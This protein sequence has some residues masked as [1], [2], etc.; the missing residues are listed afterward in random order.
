MRPLFSVLRSTPAAWSVPVRAVRTS[1]QTKFDSICS[2]CWLQQ[3]RQ[4]T[5]SRRLTDQNAFS[6]DNPAK[7]VRVNQKHG[8]GLIII[9]LIP[10]IAFGLGTWQVQRLDRK[11]QM[12]AKF[13]DRLTRPP[14]PL[15]PRIDP[16]AISEFD[17]RRVY[18]T[19]TLRHDKEMLVGP[20]INEGE[21][22][23][24]VVTPLERE[25]QSTVLVNRGWISRKLENQKDRPDGIK[26]EVVTVEG[27]L[28]EPWKK[29]MFTPDNKPEEGKFY[30]PD[31]QQMA[32]LS[33]SQ[34]V[35]IEETMVPDLVESYNREAK[36]IPIGRAAEVNLRN[37]HAQYIF[38][39]YGLSLATSIML[40]M[41]VRKKPS[42]EAMRRVRQN[43]NW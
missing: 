43:R 1:E 18:A 36:G 38:T 34:P 17:Y 28:R 8:P 15:P 24:L 25:G 29:N 23:Y 33:G 31:I 30:F 4:F 13:E 22:G 42:S 27:L 40:W 39:W 41:L 7:L 11:T 35:W 2:R 14:L 32:E 3:K 26:N 10:I 5:Q 19:G 6:V 21:D 9:A 12:I 20:R 16:E 37:N